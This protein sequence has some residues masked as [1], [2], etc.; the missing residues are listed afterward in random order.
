MR[1]D[2]NPPA[3]DASKVNTQQVESQQVATQ[4]VTTQQVTTQVVTQQANASDG[5]DQSGLKKYRDWL[6]SADYETS[7]A[8]DQAVMTLSGG[9]LAISITFIHD[10]APSPHPGTLSWLG[11]AWCA[12]GASIAS[13]LIS[14]LTSQWALRKAMRQ[15]DDLTIYS[16]RPGGGF[17]YLTNGLGIFA[18][19]A[20]LIGVSTLA[21]FAVL[22]AAHPAGSPGSLFFR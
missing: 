4:Q 7:N 1:T 6:V 12:F 16:H 18:G 19:L 2:D 14:K 11:T 3:A 15:T 5:Q 21:V 22:N 13:I 9:A 20:F 10:I 17:S 8:Y